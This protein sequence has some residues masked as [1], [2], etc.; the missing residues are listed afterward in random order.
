[1][2][3]KVVHTSPTRKEFESWNIIEAYPC[4]NVDVYI[5][6]IFI[7]S[8]IITGK[9]N[10]KTK[11]LENKMYNVMDCNYKVSNLTPIMIDSHLI[12]TL[13]SGCGEGILNIINN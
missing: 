12:G 13:I 7:F 11:E 4:I 8:V 1:M 3:I 5:A 9:Y 2:E 10:P 6:N